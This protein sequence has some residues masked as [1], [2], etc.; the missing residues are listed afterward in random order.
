MTKIIKVPGIN[1]LNKTRGCEKAPD[2]MLEELKNIYTNES[3]KEIK[4]KDLDISEIEIEGSNIEEMSKKIYEKSLEIFKN[5]EKTIFLGGDHSIS[6][7]IGKA[8]FENNKNSG[9]ESCLI[10]FDAHPDLMQPV[11][12]DAPTHEEWLRGLIESTGISGE[13]ILLVGVRNS[14]KKELDFIKEKQIKQINCNSIEE[15]IDNIADTIMEFTSSRETYL[16]LDIDVIDP[17]FA[18]GTGYCEVGGLTSRQLFY[19]LSRIKKIKSL[20]AVDLV[21]I[22]PLLDNKNKSTVKLG[23][24]ILKELI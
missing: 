12:S 16:S 11:S 14:D 23:T 6:F 4:T 19:L 7:S 13:N 9:K 2:L 15:D 1:G 18:S 10:V 20:K 8:F 21:E 24:K 3:G 22:N 17:A 5:K